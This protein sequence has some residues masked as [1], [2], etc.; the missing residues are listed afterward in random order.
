[1]REFTRWHAGFWCRY[2]P[3]RAD[4]SF[5][6]MQERDGMPEARSALESLLARA[7]D[8]ALDF[9][10]DRLVREEAIVPAEAPAAPGAAGPAA[11]R[12]EMQV[13]G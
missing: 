6:T 5:P 12:E 2:R 3:P 8:A 4:G 1:V 9:V 7:D 10:V 11:G 13:E